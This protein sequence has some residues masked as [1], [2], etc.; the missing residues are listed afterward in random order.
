MGGSQKRST[1]NLW[2]PHTTTKI[3]LTHI[4]SVGGL[5]LESI[6]ERVKGAEEFCNTVIRSRVVDMY[7]GKQLWE[8]CAYSTSI[9]THLSCHGSHDRCIDTWESRTAV[10]FN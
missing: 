7:A 4:E 1:R 10:N 2:S 3:L 6:R 8:L 9:Y 5:T